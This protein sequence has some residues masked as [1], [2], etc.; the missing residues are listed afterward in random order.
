M[1]G[2][3]VGGYLWFWTPDIGLEPAATKQLGLLLL[4]LITPGF[5]PRS[6]GRKVLA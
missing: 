4:T 6:L 3:A 2:L 1:L 5:I